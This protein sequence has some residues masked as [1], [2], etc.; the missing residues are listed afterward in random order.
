MILELLE[1]HR[2]SLVQFDGEGVNDCQ[3]DVD[4]II[5]LVK[6]LPGDDEIDRLRRENSSMSWQINPDRMGQ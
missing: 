4:N 2:D 3:S 1:K 5:D 6:R